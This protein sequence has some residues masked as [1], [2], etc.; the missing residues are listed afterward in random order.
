MSQLLVP[1]PFHWLGI[2]TLCIGDDLL[3]SFSVKERVETK[4]PEISED[5]KKKQGEHHDH[6][7]K[8][9]HQTHLPK[10]EKKAS[11]DD[12]MAESLAL[13]EKKNKKEAHHHHHHHD[14]AEKK[15]A[16]TTEKQKQHAPKE[17]HHHH[18]GE[19]K[20]TAEKKQSQVKQPEVSHKEKK[21]HQHLV[22]ERD[23]VH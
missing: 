8:A 3:F 20:D 16:V 14:A 22:E 12:L 4:K 15:D 11:P 10:V 6:G 2:I 9:S 5:K 7:H 19:T 21:H 17:H 13:A 1:H 18:H 23:E